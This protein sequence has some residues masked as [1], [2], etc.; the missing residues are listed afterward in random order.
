MFNFIMSVESPTWNMHYDMH[1]S[2]SFPL[3]RF[4]ESTQTDITNRLYPIT[5]NSLSFVENLP[6]L[7]MTE[8]ESELSEEGTKNF[9]K[10][11]VG[12]IFNLKI[13]DRD[14]TFSFEIENDFGKVYIESAKTYEKI[15]GTGSFGLHRT[16]WS[17]KD[18]GLSDVLNE[19]GLEELKSN[20]EIIPPPPVQTSNTI[21][22]DSVESFLS[23]VFSTQEDD[24][25]D[26][27]SEV[28]Y[29][30]HSNSNYKLEP[31]LFRKN[32]DGIYRYLSNEDKMTR[33]LLTVQAAEFLSD[34]YMLDKL[35]RMQHYGLP[36]RLLDVTSNPLVALY[37]A[38]SEE[39][40]D[41]DGC[42]IDG[43]VIILRT[44][45]EN[46]KF[47]DSDTVSCISNLALLST[48]MKD[49]L[50]TA[51]LPNEF[52]ESPPCSQLVHL[53]KDEKSYFE[54][55]INPND[56]EKILLVKGRILNDRISSQSGSFLIFGHNSILPETGLSNIAIQKINIRNKE[57]ILKQL[58]KLKI[59][60]STVYPGI[61]KAAKEIAKKYDEKY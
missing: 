19:L 47:F 13:E 8:M 29:R 52:N 23:I 27:L 40:K 11:R 21:F 53:I 59:N 5:E 42:D 50:N 58:N 30:G 57:V 36:T 15:L 39:H 33:E 41:K 2:S 55:K 1:G 60:E 9:V 25:N 35:V 49:A 44:G 43:Q 20:L 12:K 10:V 51:M 28:F 7:F 56:I 17:V 4:L 24:N 31:S 6:A 48:P 18:K 45:K 14:I 46:I 34:K 26:D 22:V 54:N 38:C 3:S 37:F 16:H 32:R 61:E